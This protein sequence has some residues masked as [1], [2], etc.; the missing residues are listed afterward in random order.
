M[1]AVAYGQLVAENA[2]R[3]GI[4]T[5]VISAIFHLLVTDL[6]TSA[7]ALASLPELGAAGRVAARRIV[8]VP[9]CARADWDFVAA[10]MNET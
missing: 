5:E 2:R 7:L 6:S 9:R 1:A 8:S 3:L 10:R 4:A